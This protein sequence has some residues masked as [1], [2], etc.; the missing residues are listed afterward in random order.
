[1]SLN[2]NIRSDV[3]YFDFAKAFDS[4]NH[5]LILTKLTTY[6][7][8]DSLLF[9]FMKNY[10]KEREE[11]VVISGAPDKNEVSSLEMQS[12][13]VSRLNPPLLDVLPFI[14]FFYYL[15]SS[16]LDYVD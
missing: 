10:H 16:L 13:M 2:N 3:I 7:A 1:M 14:Q 11:A 9:E 8:I 5:D 4:V 15:G 6:F 12:L